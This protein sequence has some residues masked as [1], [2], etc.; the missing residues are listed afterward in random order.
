MHA[1]RYLVYRLTAQGKRETKKPFWNTAWRGERYTLVYCGNSDVCEPNCRYLLPQPACTSFPSSA[2]HIVFCTFFFFLRNFFG[3]CVLELKLGPPALGACS[4][5]Y[6]T[7]REVLYTS[8]SRPLFFHLNLLWN[9][10][11][12]FLS[13][14]LCLKQIVCSVYT[15]KLAIYWHLEILRS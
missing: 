7:T 1:A 11:S 12:S 9:F 2:S 4:L 5:S 3:G 8:D 6:Q 10:L 15:A 14:F 13:Y